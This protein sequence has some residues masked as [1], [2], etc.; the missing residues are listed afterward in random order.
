MCK[1]YRF[2]SRKKTAM[3]FTFLL[4]FPL[5]A[6]FAAVKSFKVG[7][8]TYLIRSGNENAVTVLSCNRNFEGE[9][10]VPQTV[11]Y[12]NVTYT[13]VWISDEAFYNMPK[14][15]SIKLPISI[16]GISTPYQDSFS[17]LP[18]LEKVTIDEGNLFFESHDGVLYKKGDIPE[19]VVFPKCV[20]GTVNI[21]NN[22]RNLTLNGYQNLSSLILPATLTS[23]S[24]ID[25][26]AITSL[27]LPVSMEN[28]TTSGC[29]S[30]N[31]VSV[32]EGNPFYTA[33]D[34][35][36]YHKDTYSEM[37][38]IVFFPTDKKTYTLPADVTLSSYNCLFA[39][40]L[41]LTSLSVAT[42]HPNYVSV[43]NAIYSTE[44]GENR[45][46][47]DVAGGLTSFNLPADVRTILTI[48]RSTTEEFEE[49]EFTVL[50]L[51][52]KLE[53]LTVAAGNETYFAKGNIL[54]QN[55]GDFDI[56]KAVKV[57]CV[58]I[59]LQG[60]VVIPDE[61][62]SIGNMAFFGHTG[63]TSLS[64]PAGVLVKY[65]AFA[66]CS[67]LSDIV[68]RGDADVTSLSFKNTP[69]FDNHAPG[70]VYA[71][72]TAIDLIGSPSEIS[73]RDGTT[74][75]GLEAFFGASSLIKV[76]LPSGL[77]RI[78]TGAF[79]NCSSLKSINLPASLTQIDEDAFNYCTALTDIHLE[80]GLAFLP[81]IFADMP[82][83]SIEIPSSVTRWHEN[84]GNNDE[85]TDIHIA[86]GNTEFVS[87]NGIAY[88]KDKSKVVA[89]PAGKKN[90]TFVEG[91][92]GFFSQSDTS[93]EDYYE[94]F[95]SAN[96]EKLVLPASLRDI[97]IYTFSNCYNL[98]SC[99]VLNSDP[100]VYE[101]ENAYVF[102]DD[103][104]NVILYVPVGSESAYKS[105]NE[106]KRFG[107]IIE[108][109]I[110]GVSKIELQTLQLEAVIGGLLLSTTS[111]WEIYS[112]TGNK[113]A[114]GK[115]N[116]SIDLPAGLYMI[117]AGNTI[118]KV[119]V[120]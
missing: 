13:V 102:P 23:L 31:N 60:S 2:S 80:D 17:S 112:D 111:E 101:E 117:K 115:G 73:L 39:E 103:L 69:W 59:N 53:T 65:A 35:V 22:L 27:T 52:S 95:F 70:V 12:E 97:P 83:S 109:D 33:K 84:F 66:N 49:K 96:I 32:V 81:N 6:S 108:T 91:M 9:I 110:T 1:I 88:T 93:E 58:P 50:E 71:G 25:C 20:K 45:I 68:F 41:N 11:D 120:K 77:M 29:T 18:A 99:F 92:I 5:F 72:N 67:S 16:K 46:L 51:M 28:F 86:E 14:L 104:S 94:P 10:V 8:L 3:L 106:W 114:S 15:V 113:V 82:I 55:A 105:A 74:A 119:V 43:G 100:I 21:P 44:E 36:L 79:D 47:Y 98:K 89:V 118:K 26:T 30:L 85:L 48:R 75:I 37:R 57:A 54:Y 40:M 62:T 63:I 61:V 24:L 64:L 90:V 116:A 38:S 42:G 76:T 4:F 56:D 87:V 7:E 34:G 78:G 107:Q 19:L